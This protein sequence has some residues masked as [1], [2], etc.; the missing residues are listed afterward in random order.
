MTV[1]LPGLPVDAQ[2]SAE[3]AQPSPSAEPTGGRQKRIIQALG[4][5]HVGQSVN[6]VRSLLGREA[7]LVPER[8]ERDLWQHSGYD[9]DRELVFVL[10]FDEVLVYES[11][12]PGW[13]PFWKIYVQEGRVV[14][15]KV[16]AYQEGAEGLASVGFPPS[17]FLTRSP[18]GVK[19]TFGQPDV[20]V[21]ERHGSQQV[22]HYLGQGI[23]VVVVEDAIQVFDIFGELPLARRERVHHALSPDPQRSGD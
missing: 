4:E 9:P 15:F 18:A 19:Q 11:V 8:E 16:T 14:L 6:E 23:S 21:R 7:R 17:C 10:G 13:P 1:A 5:I 12:P 3:E 20:W 2:A 22:F